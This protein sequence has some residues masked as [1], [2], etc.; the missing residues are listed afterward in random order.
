MKSG[1]KYF[2]LYIIINVK[3]ISTHAQANETDSACIRCEAKIQHLIK[4][5]DSIVINH[6]EVILV[7]F[8]RKYSFPDDTAAII[9][10][11]KNDRTYTGYVFGVRQGSLIARILPQYKTYNKIITDSYNGDTVKISFGPKG[12][13]PADYKK[14]IEGAKYFY[15]I[16]YESK[17]KKIRLPAICYSERDYIISPILF[18]K[19]FFENGFN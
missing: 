16:V 17:G 18:S 14:M 10:I 9:N 8:E 12:P 2:L 3:V 1:W 5:W 11:Y 19:V 6:N 4:I 13:E 7:G 15:Y